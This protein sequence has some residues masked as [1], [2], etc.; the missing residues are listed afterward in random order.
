MPWDNLQ[1][2][3]SDTFDVK[4]TSQN[5]NKYCFDFLK[6]DDKHS[7][8]VFSESFHPDWILYPASEFSWWKAPFLKPIADRNHYMEYGYANAWN[9]PSSELEEQL[10]KMGK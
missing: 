10:I 9:I 1:K 4:L 7:K 5:L 8:I 3:Y 6:N 2:I